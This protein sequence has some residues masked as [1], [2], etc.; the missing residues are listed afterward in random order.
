MARK[1]NLTPENEVQMVRADMAEQEASDL[2]LSLVH[3]CYSGPRYES[4]REQYL[5]SLPT[6]LQLFD[7]FLDGN[8]YVAGDKL[9]YVD[10]I[11]YDALDIQEHFEPNSLASYSN[12]NPYLERIRGLPGV[13]KYMKSDN[14]HP[15]RLCRPNAAFLGH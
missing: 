12:I 11:V 3:V 14:Y 15:S 2:R 5:K 1:Y 10:F 7:K 9:T 6:Q 8:R 4:Q 13:D